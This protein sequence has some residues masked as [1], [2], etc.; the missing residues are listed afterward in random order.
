M[1]VLLNSAYCH[2]LLSLVIRTLF[3]HFVAIPEIGLAFPIFFCKSANFSSQEALSVQMVL[4]CL[5]G[6]EE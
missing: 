6:E 2:L 5:K 1:G 3:F 4:F